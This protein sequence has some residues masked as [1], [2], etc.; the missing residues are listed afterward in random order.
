MPFFAFSCPLHRIFT[1]LLCLDI[2]YRG[3][4]LGERRRTLGLKH[5]LEQL[6]PSLSLS[7]WIWRASLDSQTINY[8]TTG[9]VSIPWI[10]ISNWKASSLFPHRVYWRES[11]K[12]SKSQDIQATGLSPWLS[13]YS[14]L[15]F[16]PDP[17]LWWTLWFSS[18]IDV[19]VEQ[20]KDISQD[21]R[22][23]LNTSRSWEQKA[24]NTWVDWL[25]V[26]MQRRG[27]A[28]LG[29]FDVL[30]LT[31]SQE[32]LSRRKQTTMNRP[33]EGTGLTQHVPTWR[34]TLSRLW[35]Q[36]WSQPLGFTSCMQLV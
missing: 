23:T 26:A 25:G 21:R 6:L 2:L 27:L 17:F 22:L 35:E 3:D 32:W 9:N 36:H 16:V 34:Q 4:A 15:F 18:V 33:P 29:A 13:C 24:P 7:T 1:D 5:A 19:W 28:S 10:M 30:C 8:S 11:W 14:E 20:I 12:L 31:W